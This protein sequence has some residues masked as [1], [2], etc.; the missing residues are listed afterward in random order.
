MEPSKKSTYIIA[1]AAFII[2]A[3]AIYFL[4]IFQ[5]GEKK[6]KPEEFAGEVKDVA[7][8]ELA[9]RPYVTLTPTGDG[10]EIIISVEN[11]SYFDKIE[12]ELTYQA[13]NPQVPGEKIERGATGTDV[14]TKDGKYKKSMLL[15][16]ASRGTRSPDTGVTD[17]VLTMHMTKGDIEYLSESKWDLFEAGATVRSIA[18]RDGDFQVENL[19][20]GKNYWII[21]ANTVGL[22]PNS[23]P[24]LASVV[25]PT[26]GVFSIA[27]E[28]SK[29]AKLTLNLEDD[30]KNPK[31]YNFR[32]DIKWQER[33]MDYDSAKKAIFASIN[34]F[35]A[36][37]VTSQVQ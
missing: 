10:A 30:L 24:D 32:E 35:A 1:A 25:L 21:I 20:L 7:E 12:Y 13:D 9:R 36:F 17:G 23:P 2:L 34:F 18:D 4:F 33:K 11:M 37:V 31:L 15:G 27:P 28:F 6:I 14:N 22:P 8:L 29:S 19:S 5:K 3:A 26:K 16:T